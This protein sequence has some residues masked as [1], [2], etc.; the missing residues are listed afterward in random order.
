MSKSK[1]MLI[2]VLQPEECRIAIVEDGILEELYVERTS[3]EN[4]TGNIYKGRIVN[5]EPAIQAAFVD[6]SVGRNGFLHVSDVEPRYYREQLDDDTVLGARDRGRDPRSKLPPELSR[7]SGS[8]TDEDRRS[9]SRASRPDRSRDLTPDRPRGRGRDRDEPVRDEAVEPPLPFEAEEPLSNRRPLPERRR[10]W[11]R[12]RDRDRTRE[13]LRP[14]DRLADEFNDED[15]FDLDR[16]LPDPADAEPEEDDQ[17]DDQGTR[18]PRGRSR[19]RDK[20]RERRMRDRDRDRP[21]LSEKGRRDRSRPRRFGEGLTDEPLDLPEV[22]EPSEPQA[23]AESEPVDRPTP[24]R[25]RF[26]RTPPPSSRSSFE[27][28]REFGRG[29]VPDREPA[30]EPPAPR[31]GRSSEPEA[32]ET[33]FSYRWSVERKPEPEDYEA[34]LPESKTQ[35]GRPSVRPES[36]EDRP[37]DLRDTDE[38]SGGRS[39]PPPRSG[40]G[41]SRRRGRADWDAPT[42]TEPDDLFGPAPEPTSR[43]DEEDDQGTERR[44]RSGR[45][46]IRSRGDR[47]RSGRSLPR[48]PS[49]EGDAGETRE[50]EQGES[51]GPGRPRRIDRAGEPGYIPRRERAKLLDRTSDSEEPG[52]P[53]FDADSRGDAEGDDDENRRRR[54]R[55]RRRGRGDRDRDSSFDTDRD[56]SPD[57]AVAQSDLGKPPALIDESAL[58]NEFDFVDQDDQDDYDGDDTDADEQEVVPEDIEPELLEEIAREIE[59]IRVLEREV[60]FR[61][62]GTEGRSRGSADEDE[63]SRETTVMRGGR[64]VTIKPPIQEVFKRGDE[65]L[66]QVI[67][68]SIG[69]KGPTLSTYIS[70][71]GRYLVLMPGLNRVGVS[72]K[73]ADEGQ[74]RKLRQIMHELN[75]PKGLG[76]IVR[77]AGLDRSKRDLARDLAY[78]LRLWKVILRR[79]KKARTPAP[80]YQESDMIIRTIRD[81]FNSEIDTIWIDEPQAYERAREFLNVVMPRFVDR[82]K[83]YEGKVPLFQ[84]Y[85]LEEEINK[86]QR[87]QVHLPDGGSVVIDQ[88]EALVAIDVNSGN[89]RVEDDAERT[90]YEMNLKAA[91]EIA[92][93]LRLRDLGGVIVNDFIDMRD[94][95]HRRGVERALREAVKRDRA[96]TKILRMSQFGLIEMTR[97]RIRPSLKRSVY[98]ECD[99][100]GG[101]GL[102]KT[103]ESMAID[104]MRL[105]AFAIHREGV[106][107]IRVDVCEDVATFLNNRKRQELAAIESGSSISIQIC[108]VDRAVREHLVVQI[109]DAHGNE[110]PFLSN[111]NSPSSGP[112]NRRRR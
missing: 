42:P 8:E 34:N 53:T 40:R 96:R 51:T 100:C 73:I 22:D 48:G 23:K 17:A 87:R 70:I 67:K 37:A 25:P 30:E 69:T 26:E 85:G 108:P 21:D 1:E 104:A 90:A 24:T 14:R 95:R 103:V 78:L 18:A 31:R 97:Q 58:A 12:D 83:L 16:N 88:T 71:P 77:T 4:Y 92:R 44:P 93:Q 72:R 45:D 35:R 68:E 98:H 47:D 110:V 11:D 57:S 36:S 91:K 86:I 80:I 3:L 75:P 112:P 43:A 19:G 74:R 49:V 61:G 13:E 59:E 10:D 56:E 64:R 9:R 60:G 29:L 89:F 15:E 111:Q 101:G 41:P 82:L 27:G 94:E 105:I 6:F 107:S 39:G 20:I 46:S 63:E 66:V 102:V 54:R 28:S 76:F 32:E 7:G 52:L 62:R 55:R 106:R 84:K 109:V 65:V 50:T 33:S 38:D 5:I 99:H 79:I 81:I 2:N